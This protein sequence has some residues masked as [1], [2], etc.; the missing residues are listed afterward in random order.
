MVMGCSGMEGEE[1]RDPMTPRSAKLET[2]AC[3]I[4]SIH[5]PPGK[6]I[7]RLRGGGGGVLVDQKSTGS[8]KSEV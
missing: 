8:R 4:L 1:S 3:T 7:N 6:K 5:F 2:R